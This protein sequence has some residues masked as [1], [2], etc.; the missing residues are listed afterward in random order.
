LL[1]KLQPHERD[2]VERVREN[3][4]GKNLGDCLRKFARDNKDE[5][6]ETDLALAFYN[7]KAN[8]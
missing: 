2:F 4:K 7:T 8:V 6:S 3:L 1:S 5:I